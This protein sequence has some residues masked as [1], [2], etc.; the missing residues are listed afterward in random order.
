MQEH[1][2]ALSDSKLR[3]KVEKQM[4]ENSDEQRLK[5]WISLP[6]KRQVI[7]FNAGWV[8][9]DGIL[10][11]YMGSIKETQKELYKYIQESPTQEEAKKNIHSLAAKFQK[12][13][14]NAQRACTK[15]DSECR[16]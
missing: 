5:S 1:C 8:A 6:F 11:E 7:S 16:R 9:L 14:Q 15:E 2:K 13:L 10:D 4:H 3:D 12:D